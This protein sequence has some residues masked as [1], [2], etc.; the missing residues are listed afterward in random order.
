MAFKLPPLPYD[1]G[2]LAPHMSAEQL[3]LH[4]DK[5]HGKYVATLNELVSG[6]EWENRALEQIV[7]EAKPGPLLNNAAQHW[8]HSFF[9]KCLS[10]KGGGDPSGKLA[11]ELRRGF[12]DVD[13]FR[14]KFAEAALAIFGSGWAWFVREPSGKLS[15]RTTANADDPLPHGWTPVLT[16]DMWEHAFY[17]DYR[18]EKTKY[19]DAFWKVVNWEFVAA[20]L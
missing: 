1:V 4:H 15:V 5:H 11:D 19:V 6:T 10:P 16:C 8:N 2:A 12:G 13:T 3:A 14:K 7:R 20:N 18:N 17:V 9:W